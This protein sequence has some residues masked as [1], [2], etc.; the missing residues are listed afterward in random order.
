M[1]LQ[2]CTRAPLTIKTQSLTNSL[3]ISKLFHIVS[4]LLLSKL[5]VYCGII[6]NKIQKKTYN[7]YFLQF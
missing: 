7:K 3:V 6:E 1:L 5:V 2:L 4:H